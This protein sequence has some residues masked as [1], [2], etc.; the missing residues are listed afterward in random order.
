MQRRFP[1]KGRA[2][3]GNPDP[4]AFFERLK[5][6]HFAD[7]YDDADRYRDFRNVFLGTAEGRRCLY[8]IFEWA[9]VFHSS[10]V[11]GDPYMTHYQDGERS[12]GLQILSVLNA[13]PAAV[14]GL[15]V[16]L[17]ETP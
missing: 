2:T 5:D 8:Q 15:R 9:H 17:E 14:P 10:V 6:V 3:R 7:G 13:E 16:E 4:V 11:P 12:I 1:G